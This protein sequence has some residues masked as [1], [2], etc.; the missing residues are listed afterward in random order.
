MAPCRGRFPSGSF[1]V[2][3]F[4]VK[5]FAVKEFDLSEAG[6]WVRVSGYCAKLHGF[7]V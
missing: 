2:K 1:D 6:C 3:E 4:D 5:E 7:G